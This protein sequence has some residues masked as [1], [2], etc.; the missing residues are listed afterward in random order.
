MKRSK[1]N[2][3]VD[4]VSFGA[5]VFLTST[6]VLVRYVLPPGSGR[7]T[8]LWGLDRHGWGDV[9]FWVAL[10]FFSCLSAHIFLHWKWIVSL[11]KGKKREG[12]GFRVGLG[13]LGVVTVVALALAPLFVPVDPTMSKDA[14]DGRHQSEIQVRGSM[15]LAEVEDATHVPHAYL[16]REL[17]LPTNTSPSESFRSLGSRHGFNVQRVRDVVD[18]YERE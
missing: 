8:T 10:I 5:F 18:R 2:S 3:L 6:G 15:T 14:M 1:L 7:F 16:I 17:G 4:V 9:H 12:S 11:I 13:I